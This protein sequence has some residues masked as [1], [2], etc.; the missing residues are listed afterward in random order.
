V[1]NALKPTYL[2][3]EQFEVRI[4]KAGE[5]AGQGVGYL[6]DGTMI[7]VDGGRE[8]INRLIRVGVTSVLQTNAGRMIFARFEGTVAA[9][10]KSE[11]AVKA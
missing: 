1:A 7:V 6:E 4:V 5:E 11:E 10:G 2:P 8:H 9:T 3:G